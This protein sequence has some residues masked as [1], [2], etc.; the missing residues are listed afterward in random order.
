MDLERAEF[1][2]NAAK[3][4]SKTTFEPVDVCLKAV[5]FVV[6]EENQEGV[7]H[8]T[9]GQTLANIVTLLDEIDTT[10]HVK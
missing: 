1:L 9:I 8:Q 4:L 6:N 7:D 10:I 5:L 2:I 3:Q